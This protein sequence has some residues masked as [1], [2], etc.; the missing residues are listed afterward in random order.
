MWCQSVSITS[1]V[2]DKEAVKCN[3]NGKLMGVRTERSIK[4]MLPQAMLLSTC[5]SSVVGINHI[6]TI[7]HTNSNSESAVH[8]LRHLCFF[9]DTAFVAFSLQP[10]TFES[11]EHS[12]SVF[13]HPLLNSYKKPLDHVFTQTQQ[14][15]ANRLL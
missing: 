9:S 2:R 5:R 11:V 10:D 6:M 3:A 4:Y 14:Q 15:L 13:V 8:N 12:G 1:S 7:C